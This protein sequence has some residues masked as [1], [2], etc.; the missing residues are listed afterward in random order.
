[1]DGIVALDHRAVALR[2]FCHGVGGERGIDV[3][4]VGLVDAAQQSVEN[5]K[6]MKLGDALLVDDLQ[7]VAGEFGKPRDMAKLVHAVRVPRHA[8]GAGAVEAAAFARLLRQDV[9]IES[10]GRGA[11]FL[12]G[13][14]VGEMRAQARGMPGG[15]VGEVVLLD[16]HD[17]LPACLG[18]VIEQRAAHGAAADDHH[19]HVR[20]AVILSPRGS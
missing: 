16:Q 19:V 20:H 18:E 12:N 10:H 13:G 8:H 17:I 15:A 11:Q 5:G 9:T 14:V 6:R 7:R 2:H 1:M 4:I 3:A